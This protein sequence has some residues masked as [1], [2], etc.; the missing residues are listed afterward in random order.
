MPTGGKA[1]SHKKS[2]HKT[3]GELMAKSAEEL[4]LMAGREGIPQSKNGVKFNKAQ[5]A[6][7]LARHT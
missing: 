6:R 4:R 2:G 7:R 3:P 1:K 5:L